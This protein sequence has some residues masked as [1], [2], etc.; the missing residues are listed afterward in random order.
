MTTA[1]AKA[2]IDRPVSRQ[3]FVGAGR[4]ALGDA[5]TIRRLA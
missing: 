4:R 1:D 5:E 3:N 2:E